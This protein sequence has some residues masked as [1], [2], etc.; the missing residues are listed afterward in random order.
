MNTPPC[1]CGSTTGWV[2]RRELTERK[3]WDPDRKL[4]NRTNIECTE[5][6][7]YCDECDHYCGDQAFI[8]HLSKL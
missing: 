4:V 5:L 8:D 2:I 3:S 6:D 1:Q 7:V